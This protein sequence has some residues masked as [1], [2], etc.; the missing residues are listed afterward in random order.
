MQ[1]ELN[2]IATDI[3]DNVSISEL[4]SLQGY[5]NKRVAVEVN[6]QVIPR[7]EHISF[8][9]SASDKVEIIHAVGGG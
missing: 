8:I 4:L 7:G 3:Q 9:L 6:Q 2:G 1:I 5:A